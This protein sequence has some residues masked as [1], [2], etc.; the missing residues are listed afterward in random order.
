MPAY[1]DICQAAGTILVPRPSG[2]VRNRVAT[3]QV[4]RTRSLA[5]TQFLDPTVV[6]VGLTSA[7][8]STFMAFYNTNRALTFT[9]THMPD[10]STRT[11]VFSGEKPFSR[12]DYRVQAG[13]LFDLIVNLLQAS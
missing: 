9:Y 8:L 7:E 11:C 5:S 1:P 13:F 4:V 3:N 2:S 10:G 6:H 12:K